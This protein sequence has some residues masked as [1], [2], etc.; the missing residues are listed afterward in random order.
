MDELRRTRAKTTLFSSWVVLGLFVDGWAHNA[1]KP[2]TFWTPWH[3]LL[4]SGFVAAAASFVIERRRQRTTIPTDRLTMTGFLLFG[5]AG[6][7]DAAWHTAFGIEED[8]AALLSPTHLLLMLGGLLL[9]TG[10]LR[11]DDTDP[12]ASTRG[13]RTALPEL[14]AV[15]LTVAVVAFFLQFLSAF[16]AMG[17]ERFGPGAT[18]TGQLLG[19]ASLLATNVVLLAG[20]AWIVARRERFPTGAITLFLGATALLLAGLDGLQHVRLVAAAVAAGA[21]A[22]VLAHRG[23]GSRTVLLATPATLWLAWFAIRHATWGLGWPAEYWTG[24]TVLAVLTG[25]GLHLLPGHEAAPNGTVATSD[26]VIPQVEAQI[27]SPDRGATTAV[28]GGS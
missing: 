27:H 17:D 4:Y 21:V 11:G 24:V 13:W 8:V 25:W 5:A 19:V 26:G 16:H 18:E 22:D 15:T 12:H 3:G 20:V 6:L 10:P 23:S 28:G 1:G 9:I 2:E 14:V 7:G